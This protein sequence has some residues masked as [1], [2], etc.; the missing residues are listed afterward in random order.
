MQIS[1]DSQA[2]KKFCKSQKCVCNRGVHPGVCACVM[3][4]VYA[5][6]YAH[7]FWAENVGTDTLSMIL[8]MLR[9][10]IIKL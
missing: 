1:T 7:V 9:D 5:H 6:T 8:K 4:Y 3:C 10:K 2:F